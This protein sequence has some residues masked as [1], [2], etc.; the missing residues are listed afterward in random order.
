MPIYCILITILAVWFLLK[1]AAFNKE[2]RELLK[3]NKELKH[4]IQLLITTKEELK[5]AFAE[6]ASS[7]IMENAPNSGQALDKLIDQF[8]DD[9]EA[10]KN[11]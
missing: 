9:I 6:K 8:L 3:E 7:L 5:Q 11:S 10:L 2:R 4:Q 1:G